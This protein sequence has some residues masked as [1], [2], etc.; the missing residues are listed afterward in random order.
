MGHTRERVQKCEPSKV[1]QITDLRGELEIAHVMN[2]ES[3]SDYISQVQMIASQLRRNGKKLAENRIIEKVLRSL[4]DDFQNIICAIEESN[5]LS[6]LTDELM[7]SLMAYEQRRKKKLETLEEALQAKE[8]LN[9]NKSN[10]E[11]NSEMMQT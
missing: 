6:T 7:E 1:D 2:K 10:L 11:T 8:S 5:D 3:I 4:I 9:N